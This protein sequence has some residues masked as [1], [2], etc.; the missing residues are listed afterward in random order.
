[1]IGVAAVIQTLVLRIHCVLTNE[2]FLPSVYQKMKN[3]EVKGTKA[4][5]KENLESRV[6]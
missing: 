3:K 4:E 6:A 1:V 5:R 2:T